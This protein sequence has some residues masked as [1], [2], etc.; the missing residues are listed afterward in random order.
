VSKL[1]KKP[2]QLA[3]IFKDEYEPKLDI[4]VGWMG[5]GFNQQQRK[6]D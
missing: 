4:P 1:N 5:G 3:N 6:T 2:G